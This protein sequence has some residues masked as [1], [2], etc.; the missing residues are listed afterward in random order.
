MKEHFEQVFFDTEFPIQI[1]LDTIVHFELHWHNYIEIFFAL[2]GSVE[3]TTDDITFILDEGDLCFLNSG[4]V[5]SI[6]QTEI[7]NRVMTLKIS[8]SDGGPVHDL[9]RLRF[10]PYKYLDDLSNN[11]VPLTTF[12]QILFYLYHEYDK[13]LP[14]YENMIQ[15][16]LNAL[17]GIMK[18]RGYLVLKTDTDQTLDRNLDRL[19][20]ILQYLDS[21]Y[22]EP[23]S[24]QDI[25]EKMH[26][27]YHYLSHFF[28]NIAGISFQDYLS[29]LRL[30]KSLQLLKNKTN[31][32]TSIA[33]DT[34]F[35]GAKSYTRSFKNKYGILP[36]EYRQNI[37]EHSGGSRN[38]AVS[39]QSRN[40]M[41]LD[42]AQLSGNGS[43]FFNLF[44]KYGKVPGEPD[45]HIFEIPEENINVKVHF[46]CDSPAAS[47][48][49]YQTA[50]S[51]SEKQSLVLRFIP[52]WNTLNYS[53]LMSCYIFSIYLEKNVPLFTASFDY[54]EFQDS[55]CPFHTGTLLYTTENIPSPAYWALSVLAP[56]S[57]PVFYPK[58]D[59]AISGSP[60]H[61]RII[62]SNRV[63]LNNFVE[64]A[65]S[66][67]F[68]HTAYFAYHQKLVAKNYKFVLPDKKIY[69]G[70]ITSIGPSYGSV[71]DSWIQYG[72]PDKIS[73]E[74][75]AYLKRISVPKIRRILS[76]PNNILYVSAAPLDCI[77]IEL[78]A[79][80]E[81]DTG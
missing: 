45:R 57:G 15:S 36:S 64:N 14:G 53:A 9:W 49:K 38:G 22:Q 44:S 32:I 81:T 58:E 6:R 68:T 79:Q 4:V 46:P 52:C 47:T 33:L 59:I 12:Q 19:N 17:F 62:I 74:D 55:S 71:V 65:D 78:S 7:K 11:R 21:H 2:E 26:M 23:L 41:L 40:N 80:H 13:K 31:T 77:V 54:M 75:I 39:N 73:P 43:A 3:I 1:D 30:D 18:R 61:F 67:G 27:N 35:P 70:K 28:K 48:I 50:C 16:L 5:H 37:L 56:V 76:I 42:S 51:E 29:Q 34:G 63:Q 8:S 72:M 60:E 25:A 20:Y 69:Q 10:D 66:K 24:L